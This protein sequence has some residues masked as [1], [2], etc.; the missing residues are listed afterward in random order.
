MSAKRILVTAATLALGSAA[1]V[2]CSGTS[3][4]SGSTPSA[5]AVRATTA[6]PSHATGTPGTHA[7][8]IGGSTAQ[9]GSRTSA[10]GDAH[11][12]ATGSGNKKAPS[13]RADQLTVTAAPVSR[14]LNHLLIT[15]KN[16]SGSPCD[17]GIIGL[18]TFDGKIRATTPDGIGGG[19][20]I[21]QPGQSSY[22]GVSLDQ[23][24]APGSGTHTSTLSVQLD[25]GDTVRIPV[26]TYVH[27]PKITVWEP[28][29][30][31]A[32]VL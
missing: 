1:V 28:T 17:L 18:V 2:G 16:T 3:S 21:L 10:T 23:Q 8:S 6:S 7:S 14:P 4:A 19:P 20:N 22:E 12:T 29:A 27:A 11:R 15:A 30:A 26:K 24:D 13:C 5:S 32:L 31:D 25:G 9:A